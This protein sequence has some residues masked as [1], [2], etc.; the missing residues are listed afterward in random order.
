MPS[1][2]LLECE[3]TSENDSMV[4]W[5]R[6]KK[7]RGQADNTSTVRTIQGTIAEGSTDQFS[8]TA[9]RGKRGGAQ[10]GLAL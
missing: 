5:K 8:I 3:D 7:C 10:S 2:L 6:R 9:L 4:L 1:Y